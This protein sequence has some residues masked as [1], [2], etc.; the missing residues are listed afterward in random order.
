MLGQSNVIAVIPA[1]GGS[2][3]VPGKNIKNLG[4]KPLIAWSIEVAKLTRAVDRV[5]VSTDDRAI[6]SVAQACGAE[7]HERPAYLATDEAIVIDTVRNLIARLEGEGEKDPVMVL[8]EPTCPFRTPTDVEDCLGLIHRGF[9]S[10][11]TF[12]EAELNPHRA[13]RIDDAQPEVFIP[14]AVPWLPRQ[15]L[16][17]AYQLN[18]AVYA[19]RSE[20]L[21]DSSNALLF[22][23]MGAV[24]MPAERSVDIDGPLDFMLAELL[25]K[26]KQCKI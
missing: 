16:P 19:F 10:V 17:K 18:G 5:I 6:G 1:R 4:D 23:K 12:R 3:S 13:W 25:I 14:G 21:P 15:R 20:R 22:G 7:F 11:A 26:G 9:D 8:L 2:K 24:I